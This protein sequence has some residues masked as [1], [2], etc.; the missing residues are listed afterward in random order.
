MILKHLYLFF[1]SV[2]FLI[3]S[4][5][6]HWNPSGAEPVSCFSGYGEAIVY[7]IGLSIIHY[8]L[9]RLLAKEKSKNHILLIITISGM[10]F[11]TV[12]LTGLFLHRDYFSMMLPVFICLQNILYR[13]EVFFHHLERHRAIN[14]LLY[15]LSIIM[16]LCWIVWILMMGYLISSRQEPRWI[17]SLIYNI[18][19]IFLMII[20]FISIFDLQKKMKIRILVIDDSIWLSQLNLS[21]FLG[22]FKN[23]ILVQLL[24]NHKKQGRINCHDLVKALSDKDLMT[25]NDMDC[26]CCKENKQKATLCKEYRKIYR[27]ILDIKKVLELMQIGTIVYPENKMDVVTVGWALKLNSNI[28]I[29]IEDEKISS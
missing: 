8:F 7:G 21:E 4:L 10:L 3:L 19:N 13:K 25:I 1:Y 27:Q 20:F 2:L 12:I 28:E 6:I 22:L 17:E 9:Y 16:L 26:M 23:E 18:Y 11:L 15:I 5:V 14:K 29:I 24:V